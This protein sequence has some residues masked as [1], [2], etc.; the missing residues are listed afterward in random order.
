MRWV[1]KIGSALLTN[2]GENL[3][4]EAIHVWA[5]QMVALR[6]EKIELILVSSGAVAEGM[7]RLGW[8]RRPERIHELQAAA[9]VGQMG[10]I[11]VYEAC[12][13]RHGIHTAQILLTH[14]D[15]SDRKRYLNVGSTLRALLEFGVLPIV[16]EN[17]TVA[18]DEIRLGDNDTL[19]G[20]VANLVE[21]RRLI[22][23]TDQEGLYTADPRRDPEATLIRVASAGDVE[24]E[25]M[26]GEG[27][28]LGRG[29]MRTKITA[30]VLAARSG[31][32]TIIAS[33]RIRDVLTRIASG[34]E[35]GSLIKPRQP[36]LAARKRWLAGS[37]TP[38][39]LILDAGAVH[40]LEKKGRSLLGVGVSNVEGNFA[41]GEVVA[42][43]DQ[44]G[45]EI[46]HGLVNYDAREI[47]RLIGQPS[48]RI[49]EILG[50]AHEP[51]LIHRDNL[52]LIHDGSNRSRAMQCPLNNR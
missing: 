27:S 42:C 24:L 47:R 36:M 28:A 10:L 1:I 29:G 14:D 48:D 35:I 33:G 7:C 17:D 21:A 12:F 46:A 19:A 8:H 38:G 52:V 15:F 49:G 9:A 43:L 30:A 16:N 4:R 3:D 23:L 31:T 50:Y 26:A 45:R 6:R 25:A 34:E 39:R 20:L 22:M 18:T 32:E 41:R 44:D 13:Q 37:P 11:R 5:E 51:E 40:A 2:N